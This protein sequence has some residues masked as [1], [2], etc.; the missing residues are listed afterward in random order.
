MK[1]RGDGSL[2]RRLTL[3]KHPGL[4]GSSGAGNRRIARSAGSVV[5][6]ALVQPATGSPAPV[7]DTAVGMAVIVVNLLVSEP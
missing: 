7:A 6:F 3:I 5:A 2:A 4:L 1:S